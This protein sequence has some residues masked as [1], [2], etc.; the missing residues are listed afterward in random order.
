MMNV[1]SPANLRV[2]L[3]NAL[4]IHN[5]INIME[6]MV[7]LKETIGTHTFECIE[8]KA[9]IKNTKSMINGIIIQ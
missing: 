1:I 2:S 6:V 4:I 5:E 3:S 7:I 8:L 9:K